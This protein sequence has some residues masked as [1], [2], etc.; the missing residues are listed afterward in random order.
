MREAAEK[1][2][3]DG[4]THYSPSSGFEEL[5]KAVAEKLHRDN[6][7]SYDYESEIVI[8]PGSS[9]GIFLAMLSLLDP[10]DEALVPDPA[11]FHYATLIRLCGAKPVG[12]PVKFKDNA[13]SLDLE[14][15]ERRLTDRT[16]V[17]IIIATSMI[18]GFV[19]VSCTHSKT[20][21]YQKP[22]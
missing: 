21:G 7:I 20:I 8:T 2:I 15:T 1:A 12:M 9:S 10:G 19:S 18:M 6:G 3:E 5:R 16:K 22:R 4:F 14:E 17:L 13:S 11:W